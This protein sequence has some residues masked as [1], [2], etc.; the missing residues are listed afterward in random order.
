MAAALCVASAARAD[1]TAD[2]AARATALFEQGQRDVAAGHIDQACDEFATSLELDPQVGTRLNLADCRERQGRN[3]EAYV[4]YERAAIESAQKGKEGREGFARERMQV[5]DRKLVRV[6]IH[7]AR[8]PA[9]VTVALRSRDIDWSRPVRVEPGK[10]S[11]D[12]SAP[13][14]KEFHREL[15]GAAGS[16]LAIEVPELEALPSPTTPRHTASEPPPPPPPATPHR[17]RWPI[18]FLSGG[19]ALGLGSLGL[20]L[21]AKSRWRTATDARDEQGVASAQR[22]ADF[23]TGVAVAGGVAAVVGVVLYLRNRDHTG[24]H[25]AVAPAWTTDSV[26]LAIIAPF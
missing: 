12:V 15:D 21:H 16:E 25:V 3:A 14:R 26:G 5:L 23:A 8:P 7:L 4:L 17:S 11:I 20:A 13:G 22:E 10:L 1:V 24:D 19:A 9:G 18:A 2:Q 6:T